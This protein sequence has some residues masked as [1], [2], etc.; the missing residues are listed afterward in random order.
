MSKK[1][2]LLFVL[3]T[4]PFFGTKGQSIN[5]RIEADYSI[6][7][8]LPSGKQS[9]VMGR[10]FYDI[11]QKTLTHHHTFPQEQILLYKDTVAYLVKG[12]DVK[13]L[14]GSSFTVNFSIYHLIL[15]NK[16]SNFGLDEYGYSLIDTERIEDKI[17]TKWAH[18]DLGAGHI[19]ITQIRNLVDGVIFYSG[20]NEVLI[21]QFFK[22]YET[23]GRYRIPTKI[24][25]I[26][27]LGD[28]ELKKMTEHKNIK[29]DDYSDEADYYDCFS[30]RVAPLIRTGK[31][32]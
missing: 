2:L 24:F 1:Q 22:N 30:L 11:N 17:V 14:P 19:V 5:T 3:A 26:V 7:E 28:G 16:A 12:E 6:K 9:L 25:E 29:I 31:V 21:R 23:F 13:R 10:V 8:V 27:S 15:S 4:L 20:E 18:P 32:N